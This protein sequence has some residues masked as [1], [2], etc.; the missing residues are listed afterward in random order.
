MQVRRV[1]GTTIQLK[2]GDAASL[3]HGDEVR[4]LP[5][6]HLYVLEFDMCRQRLPLDDVAS[7]DKSELTELLADENE[8]VCERSVKRQRT[9]GSDTTVC[10]F[11]HFEA[12]SSYTDAH[13]KQ[14]AYGLE[15]LT[16][17]TGVQ[18]IVEPPD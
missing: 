14:A 10:F 6:S 8:R 9:G 5:G 12:A 3:R 18:S 4:L 11:D 1:F 17:D 13:S 7:H 2:H 15:Q 16:A